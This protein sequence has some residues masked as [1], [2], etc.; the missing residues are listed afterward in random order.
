MRDSDFDP[1]L[2][3]LKQRNSKLDHFFRPKT[4]AVIGA[5]DKEG[6]VGRTLMQNL[7][8]FEGTI[9]PVNPNRDTVFGLK[10]YAEVPEGVDLAIVVTPA[11]TVPAIIEACVKKKVSAAVIISAGFKEMGEPGIALE[12][13][14]AKHAIAGKMRI[15]G[16]NCLGV[17]NPM[18]GLNATFAADMARKGNIA[19]ISQ[20]G[21]LCTAVLD[22]S[23]HEKVGFSAFVSIGSMLDVN[24]GDLI[25]YFGNDPATKS[26]LIYMESI[27]DPRAFLS[28]AR[29]VAL[30]KPI[31]LIKAGR[32]AESASAAASHTGALAGSDDALNAALRRVG[33][34]RV[35][36]IADLFG[37]AEVLAKQ[38]MPKGPHLAILTNAGGPGVIATDALILN[39]GKLA[40]VSPESMDQYNAFLPAAWSHNNPIDILGDASADIYSKAVDVASKDPNTEGLLVILTPQDMTDPTKTALALQSFSKL[41]IPVFTSWMGA[42]R[43]EKGR[44]ILT[45]AG[46]PTFDFPDMA[47]RTFASM[48]THNYNLKA[49]YEVP[50][51]IKDFE[52]ELKVVEEIITSALKENRTILDEYESKRILEAYQIPTVTTR[53]AKSEQEALEI[54]STMTFPLVLKLYSRTITHKSD[55]GGVKLNLSNLE[56][57]KKAYK[58]IKNA[59][60]AHD[61]AGVTVQPMIHLDG[62][63]LILGSTIDPEFGPVLLFGSGGQL[64]EVYKDR[65]LALPPLTTTLATRFMEQTKIYEALHGVRGRKAI[66]LEKLQSILVQFSRM[67]VEQKWIKECDINPLLVSSDGMI[68]LDARIILHEAGTTNFPKPAIR[69]YPNQYVEKWKDFI[70]RPIR[71]D[72]EPKMKQ[73]HKDLSNET[74]RQRYLKAIQYEERVAHERLQRICFNDYDREIAIVAEYHDE[75]LGIIRLSKVPKSDE[76]TISMTVKD[77]W[78]N[79]GIGSKLMEK[80]LQIAKQE[81]VQHIT[82]HMLEENR[83]MQKLLTRFHFTLK[84]EENIIIASL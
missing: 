47:C 63:E 67:I 54:A 64:V 5:T 71:P 84:K 44:E 68:A 81:N 55:V 61:F 75:I 74:V 70:L 11:K 50:N 62:Y 26:I 79:K 72:D 30:T 32:S 41:D 14:I 7:I 9:I 29:E 1:S 16:P 34:L 21:A 69:A 46:I 31:I 78:Q 66:D 4:I 35:D 45:T 56:A 53:V 37:M 3:F 19:F 48:W 25:D 82:A 18:N 59:V 20:S 77:Q 15:I 6:S 39:G 28:A 80:I 49:I 52:I 23:I 8:S 24:W 58:E 83:L 38:P 10:A 76:A 27:G 2:N 73:F 43:V 60:S 17:M 65:S 57:V 36:T 42:D 12:T 13:Q 51:S 40:K 22:W 33:V